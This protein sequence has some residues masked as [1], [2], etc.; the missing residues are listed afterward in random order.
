MKAN[1]KPGKLRYDQGTEFKNRTFQALLREK[2]IHGCEA[3]NDTNAAIMECFN[4][5][6]KNKMYRAF[7]ARN[8]M[9]Y[10]DIL[11]E[12]VDSYNNTYHRSIGV[13]PSEVNSENELRIRARLFPEEMEGRRSKPK[14]KVGDYVRISKN[15]RMFEKWHAPN[16]T[17]ETFKVEKVLDTNPRPYLVTDLM[18]QEI[19]GRIYEKQLE[20]G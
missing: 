20:K 10:V 12:L 17:E 6:L 14:F 1:K 18:D 5:T 19:T 3:I 15:K 2:G 9:R 13:K 8:N 11:R 4:R 16:W 7:T